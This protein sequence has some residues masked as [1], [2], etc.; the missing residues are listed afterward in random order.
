MQKTT[1][2]LDCFDGCSIIYHE[3]SLKGD[4]TH[5]I[6]KG[7]L[8]PHLNNW[9]KHKRVTKA[10]Y[11]DKEIDLEKAYKVLMQKLHE[12]CKDKILLYKGSG[13]LGL[14]QS[15]TK[16]FFAA[17]GSVIA[18]GSLC[19]GAGGAG[20]D[21]GRG[22]NLPL[23]PLEVAKSD[24]VILWGRNPSI[25]NSHMLNALKGKKLIVIDPRKT[26]L[27][28]KADI[29]VQIKPGGDAYLAFLLSR[30]TSMEELEDR[31]FIN[32][33]TDG[34]DDFIDFI[35]SIPMVNLI[36]KCGIKNLDT[37][38]DI[39]HLIQDKKVSILV[40]VGVQNY[41]FG[42]QVLHAIDSFG[43]QFG[44]FGKEG[45]GV[46]YLSNSNFGFKN[47]FKV[48]TKTDSLVNADF[49]KYDMVFIQGGN[50]AS[51]MPN[52]HK[53][54]ENLSKSKFVVYFG[55]HEN[56]TSKLANLIIPA[57][58]FLAKEDVKT[59]YGHEFVGLMP[60]ITTEKFAISEYALTCKIMEEFGYTPLKTEQA[61]IQGFLEDN[62]VEQDGFIKN[63]KSATTPYKEGFYTKNGKFL[64]C[65]EL[66]DDFK[67]EEGFY[68]LNAKNKNS[69]NSQFKTDD[70]LYVPVSLGL[71]DNDVIMLQANEKK[72][73]YKVKNSYNLREDCFLLYSG[74][75]NANA[76]TQDS[77]SIEGHCAIYRE[78]KVQ[79]SKI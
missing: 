50:P 10:R 4:K 11:N 71:K 36:E 62:T 13:N 28:K 34:Y 79:W 58:S 30:I 20:V 37:I 3:H 72:C 67:E 15:V 78:L 56:E 32:S 43:A 68:L 76:L 73:T 44:L 26:N 46:G 60:K 33:K 49:S 51:Q 16:L 52:S 22:A 12:T 14:M 18:K 31:E 29:H 6:T 69:L 48:K 27:A 24:V 5:P 64:F 59:S 35:S 65:D 66:D 61:Y 55:L 39:L 38:G 7:F 63:K 19:D 17:H 1:C 75:K 53:V 47:P 8:C 40:G 57:C 45:C 23:S 25:T 70:Y 42:H 9:H 41:S 54:R 2:P 77:E 21:M 74:N